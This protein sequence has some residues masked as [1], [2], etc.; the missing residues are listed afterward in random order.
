M[1]STS[2]MGHAKVIA[3]FF[4]LVAYLEKLKERYS[5][6]GE[7]LSIPSLNLQ[8]KAAS[9]AHTA[10]SVA[11]NGYRQLVSSRIDIF[12]TIKEL[13][14]RVK[15]YLMLVNAD[16]TT[17]NAAKG[18]ASKITGSSK[19]KKSDLAAASPEASPKYIS[20]S[21]RSFDMVADNFGKLVT[22]IEQTPA[23]AAKEP[24][25]Q[26]LALRQLYTS[27]F[28]VN[29]KVYASEADLDKARTLRNE[30][31]YTNDTS[32]YQLSKSIKLYVKAAF[33]STSAEY[34]AVCSYEVKKLVR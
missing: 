8:V 3:N 21:Q 20:T 30:L 25:L 10:I 2:E 17:L 26:P 1:V 32:L 7:N 23:Y 6:P 13:T 18:L 28:D 33:G 9:A 24:E 16:V 34:D 12:D 15:N 31:L 4:D 29:R 19:T 5:P 14:P 22:L 11:E 27:A